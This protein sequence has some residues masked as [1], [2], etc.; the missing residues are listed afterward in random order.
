MAV[1]SPK[2]FGSQQTRIKRFVLIT[3]QETE[4]GSHVD[5]QM[6][7]ELSH[8]VLKSQ[9]LCVVQKVL[10]IQNHWDLVKRVLSRGCIQSHCQVWEGR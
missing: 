7:L 6:L 1:S 8:F 5:E 4:L 2:L 9:G 10:M 3:V